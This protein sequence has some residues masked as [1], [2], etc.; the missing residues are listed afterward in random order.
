M[1]GRE[2]L[3]NEKWTKSTKLEGSHPPKLACMHFTSTPTCLNFLSWFYF[4]TPMDYSPWSEGKVWLFWRQHKRSNISETGEVTPTKIGLHAFHAQPL[5]A[6]KFLSQFY[7]LT[8]MDY[9]PWS[10][11]EFWPFSKAYGKGSIS[12]KLEKVTPTKIGLHAFRVNLYLL[13]VFEPILFFDP[14]GL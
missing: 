1:V 12:Q 6:L 9:S 4:F 8:P 13:K 7:F 3:A 2:I 5:L 10:E 14:H 11:G